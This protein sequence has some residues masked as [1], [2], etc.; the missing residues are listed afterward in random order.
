MSSSHEAFASIHSYFEHLSLFLY[1]KGGR[2]RD[3]QPRRL[4]QATLMDMGQGKTQYEGGRV[5]SRGMRAQADK[6]RWDEDDNATDCIAQHGQ[7]VSSG[8]GT[9]RRSNR[10]GTH[11]S[12]GAA[13]A[14]DATAGATKSSRTPLACVYSPLSCPPSRVEDLTDPGYVDGHFEEQLEEE[15]AKGEGRFALDDQEKDLPPAQR[16]QPLDSEDERMA[17]LNVVSFE[18]LRRQFV[19]GSV[20]VGGKDAFEEEEDNKN[21]L[22]NDGVGSRGRKRKRGG[23]R[24]G[25]R[26]GKKGKWNGKWR[27]GLGKSGFKRR[28]SS[29]REGRGGSKAK[30]S[31]VS[32][33]KKH[34]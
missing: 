24:V 23:S 13:G 32:T 3:V 33:L 18:E 9:R 19:G 15:E 28:P 8:G 22:E 12:T 11:S 4:V 14:R 26:W 16:W 5:G 25:W 7:R 2:A 10:S 6:S 1:W 29:R 34:V 21:A 20:G 31:N 27:G 17:T 30:S